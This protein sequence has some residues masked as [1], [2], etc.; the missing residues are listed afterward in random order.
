MSTKLRFTS[1][2]QGAIVE[3]SPPL[4]DTANFSMCMNVRDQHVCSEDLREIAGALN[5]M[6]DDMDHFVLTGEVDV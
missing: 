2:P 6:A 3:L 5:Q 4:Y 1:E